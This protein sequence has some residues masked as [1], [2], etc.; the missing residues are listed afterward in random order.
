MPHIEFQKINK[1]IILGT[2]G[3]AKAISY[4]LKKLDIGITQVS[5]NPGARDCISYNDL[6]DE[7]LIEN[8]LIVNATPLGMYPHINAKPRL[9]YNCLTASH[10]LFDVVYN[11]SITTFLQKGHEQGSKTIGGVQMLHFQAEKSWEIWNDETV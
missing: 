5:R 10:I 7:M 3:S 1:A 2:G 4:V 9:N 6:T 11:P 8:K